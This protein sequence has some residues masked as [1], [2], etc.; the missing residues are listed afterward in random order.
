MW[1]WLAGRVLR[2]RGGILIV[3]GLLTAFMGYEATKVQMNYKH[4]GLLPKSDPAYHCRSTRACLYNDSTKASLMMVFVNAKLFDTDA[5]VQVID[6]LEA[7]L[8]AFPAAT[9]M[10]VHDQ[11]PAV[12]PCEEHPAGEGRDALVHG[13]EH[14]ICALLLLLFFQVLARDVDLPGRGGH[15]R[16]V[17]LRL[18]WPCSATRSPSC[19]R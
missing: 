3:V 15:Q 2:N 16:G 4:G 9:G 5:R 18:P 11:R 8:N 19:N 17:G 13:A 6:A 7:R 14:G 10:P 12:D 1:A